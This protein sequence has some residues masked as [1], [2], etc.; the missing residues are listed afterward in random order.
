MKVL[1]ISSRWN[2]RSLGFDPEALKLERLQLGVL[3]SGDYLICQIVRSHPKTQNLKPPF[4]A[5]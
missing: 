5:K 3:L 4:I 1:L 2:N